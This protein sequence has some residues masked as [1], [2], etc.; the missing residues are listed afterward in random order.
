[1][2]HL[3]LYFIM[4]Y[5]HTYL[6]LKTDWYFV[7]GKALYAFCYLILYPSVFL[8]GSTRYV[9]F[10][11]RLSEEFQHDLQAHRERAAEKNTE[12]ANRSEELLKK[13]D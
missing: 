3:K 5:W 2:K 8:V 9:A 4:L 1:M 7:K 13:V 11:E 12:L 10:V 6:T